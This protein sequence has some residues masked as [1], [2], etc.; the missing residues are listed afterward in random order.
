MT[1]SDGD[2][3]RA[4]ILEVSL[5]LFAS[6]GYDGVGMRALADAAHVN[7]ATIA[8]H[9]GDKHGLYSEVVR[10][11][12]RELADLKP[13]DLALGEG[14][15]P[16][17]SAIAFMWRFVREHEL[18][19]RLLHRHLLDQGA[20]TAVAMEEVGGG[21]LERLDGWL[22]LLKPGAPVTE[23]RLIAMTLL[24]LLV[25]FALEPAEQFGRIYATDEDPDA[26]IV[27]W[28][29]RVARSMLGWPLSPDTETSR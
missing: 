12:Y 29:V 16:M 3:T 1:R 15:D 14:T 5:P 13:E 17:A 18:H 2:R 4:R 19:I 20:H 25:R 6:H 21:L 8:W 27:R 7:V 11:I 23:L 28:L 10:R 22:Q 24:H 9:F 26:V